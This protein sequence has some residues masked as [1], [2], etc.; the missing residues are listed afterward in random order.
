MKLE[1]NYDIIK[2]YKFG[3]YMKDVMTLTAHAQIVTPN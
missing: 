3:I 2:I 1:S